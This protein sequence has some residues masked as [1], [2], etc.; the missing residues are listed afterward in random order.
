M[1]QYNFL[2]ACTL[3]DTGRVRSPKSVNPSGLTVR[4]F[5]NGEVFPSF[6]LVEKFNLE[7]K[8]IDSGEVTYGFDVLDSTEWTPLMDQPRMIIFGVTPKTE[9]KVDLF[10]TCRYTEHGNPKISVKNQGGTSEV[11][12]A[13]VRSMGYLTDAQK[14]CDLELVTEFPIN[15]QD[16]ISHIPKVIERG[17]KKGEKTNIRR[18]NVVY[19]PVNT[20]ENLEEMRQAEKNKV[21][22]TTT[23]TV[24]NNQN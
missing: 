11:L 21:V 1:E 13:L 19:Y 10:S 20:V 12:L 18:D 8:A 9:P 15:M 16:G 7:Y 5:S 4:I 3:V 17:E 2:R 24:V 14:Y 23:E 6:E 22:T